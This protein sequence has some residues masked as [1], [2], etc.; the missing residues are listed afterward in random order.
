MLIPMRWLIYLLA[1][2]GILEPADDLFAAAAIFC[3]MQGAKIG[4]QQCHSLQETFAKTMRRQ[5][6]AP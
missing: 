2:I 5:K 3:R 4:L 6:K 1:S